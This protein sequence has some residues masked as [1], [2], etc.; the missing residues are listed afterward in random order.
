MFT[1]IIL[2]KDG[3]IREKKVKSFDKLYGICNYRSEEGFEELHTWKKG[4]NSFVLFGKR[5]G[6]NNC[7]NKYVL[8]QPLQQELLYG[9]LCLIKK[10]GDEF[11]SLDME[12]WAK[13]LETTE[14]EIKPEEK[15]LKK[16]EYEY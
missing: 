9:N 16:E 13:F 4:E 10:V 3:A 5:K 2:E 15:E 12:E 8:P 7:E 11:R 1:L 6:K 14:E